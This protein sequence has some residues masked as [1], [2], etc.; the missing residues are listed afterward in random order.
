MQPPHCVVESGLDS[1]RPEAGPRGDLIDREVAVVAERDD[2]AVVRVEAGE[3][4]PELIPV[5]GG[6][7][8]VAAL[9]DVDLNADIDDPRT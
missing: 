2:E 4:D 7:V 6:G 1:A 3:S 8:W 5:V 9:N